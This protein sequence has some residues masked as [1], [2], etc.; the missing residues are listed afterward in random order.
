VLQ[1]R[2]EVGGINPSRLEGE[3]WT[4]RR[5]RGTFSVVGASKHKYWTW[6]DTETGLATS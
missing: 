2:V 4:D 1:V 6:A 5:T 3:Y